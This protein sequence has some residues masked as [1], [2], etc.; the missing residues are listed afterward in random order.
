MASTTQQSSVTV[1]SAG[2]SG[3]PAGDVPHVG[4]PSPSVPSGRTPVLSLLMFYSRRRPAARL[5]PILSPHALPGLG[6]PGENPNKA[7]NSANAEESPVFQIRRCVRY[8]CI[9]LVFY[10]QSAVSLLLSKSTAFIA[11]F[12]PK[13]H[14]C[15]HFLQFGVD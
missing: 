11:T 13:R 3:A 12:P 10:R 6:N 7:R 8:R 15:V 2:V 4:R 9:I 14:I 1:K 5:P